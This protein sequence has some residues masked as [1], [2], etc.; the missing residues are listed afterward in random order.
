MKILILTILSILLLGSCEREPHQFRIIGGKMWLVSNSNIGD[1][2]ATKV[3]YF[4]KGD[5]TLGIL[6]RFKTETY[7]VEELPRTVEG[8]PYYAAHDSIV[9][10]TANSVMTTND[11]NITDYFMNSISLNKMDLSDVP[12][13]V[14]CSRGLH[15]D[16]DYFSFD[17][18]ESLEDFRQVYNARDRAY[19]YYSNGQETLE[20]EVFFW[21][22]DTAIIRSFQ[23]NSFVSLDVEF[24]DRIINIESERLN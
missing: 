18:Y 17:L 12:C 16:R 22:E 23:E 9:S 13:E 1:Y 24:N 8:I 20:T 10:I 3:N 7:S 5:P 19:I 2:Y 15:Q 11:T 4:E 6:L 14:P 21:I